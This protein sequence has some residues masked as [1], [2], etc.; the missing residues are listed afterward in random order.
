[1]IRTRQL[2]LISCLTALT[3]GSLAGCAASAIGD[4]EL[5]SDTDKALANEDPPADG[6]AD[7][8][9]D[10]D[11]SP[12]TTK[13]DSGVR[14]DASTPTVADSGIRD[15]AP[16]K[17]AGSSTDAGSRPVVDASTTPPKDASTPPAVVDAGSTP[18]D[19]GKP[20]DPP[21]PSNGQCSKDSD[22]TNV[23]IA[24]GILPCCTDDNKCGC[25]WAPGTYC[26]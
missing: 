3:S 19:A 16:P 24:I 11:D 4:P 21:P 5:D 10:D 6:G 22:C 26:L 13:V 25:T 15:A 17:D 20:A 23:C 9:Q 7:E 8:E 1:M 2:V 12:P 14:K 18:K